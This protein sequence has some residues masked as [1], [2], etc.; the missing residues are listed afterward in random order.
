MFDADSDQAMG[1]I[2]NRRGRRTGIISVHCLAGGR[3]R[4]DRRQAF[5]CNLPRQMEADI[6]TRLSWIVGR[7]LEHR[8]SPRSCADPRCDHN[9]ADFVTSRDCVSRRL[10]SRAEE[11]VA[12]ELGPKPE[13]EIRNALEQEVTVDRWTR[14]DRKIRMVADEARR[15]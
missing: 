14:L 15:H 9:G 3:W 7:S 12:I 4:D 2:S 8:Q 6:S 10:R 5:T 11:L 1:P 13:H